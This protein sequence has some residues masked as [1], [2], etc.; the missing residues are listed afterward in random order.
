MAY[1]VIGILCLAACVSITISNAGGGD[2]ELDRETNETEH[3]PDINIAN[4]ETNND[5]QRESDT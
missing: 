3:Q 4:E 2:S 1:L 5:E